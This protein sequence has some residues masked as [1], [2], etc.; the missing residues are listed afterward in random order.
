MKGSSP[1]LRYFIFYRFLMRLVKMHK[2]KKVFFFSFFPD[3]Q[4]PFFLQPQMLNLFS[5]AAKPNSV[6]LEKTFYYVL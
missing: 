5:K 3:A 6:V 2:Y 1:L 4:E